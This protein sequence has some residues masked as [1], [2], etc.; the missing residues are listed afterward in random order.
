MKALTYEKLGTMKSNNNSI[1]YYLKFA[2]MILGVVALGMLAVN[3]VF[4]YHYH[5]AFLKTPCQLCLNENE[6]LENCFKES[7]TY[8]LNPLLKDWQINYSGS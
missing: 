4:E 1:I 7:S 8:P 2:L 5:I 6:F 3:Q